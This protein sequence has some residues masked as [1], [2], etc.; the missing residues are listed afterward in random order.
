MKN[1]RKETDR[2]RNELINLRNSRKSISEFSDNFL[3][4]YSDNCRIVHFVLNSEKASKSIL[5]T[6]SRQYFVFLVSSWE[7]YFRDTFVYIYTLDE[8][9][10]EELLKHVLKHSKHEFTTQTISLPEL[11]SKNFNFQNLDDIKTSFNELWKGDFLEYVC[12]E[13]TE[14]CGFNGEFHHGFSINQL[15]EDW[16]EIIETS[17]DIRHKVV[18]DANYRLKLDPKFIQKSEALFLMIPQ[19]VTYFLGKRF[20]LNLILLSDGKFVAPYIFSIQD[21]LAD[22]WEIVEKQ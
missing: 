14:I 19:F 1:I 5:L 17:F 4:N 20:N 10:L 15:F 12:T 13:T 11:L 8:K 18:H 9:L 7:T 6:A 16:K 3:K 21:I 2:L 22:D